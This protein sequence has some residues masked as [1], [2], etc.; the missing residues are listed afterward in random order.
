M[1]PACT[2]ARRC[3][4]APEEEAAAVCQTARMR[5]FLALCE[6]VS[7]VP[8]TNRRQQQ[9]GSYHPDRFPTSSLLATFCMLRRTVVLHNSRNQSVVTLFP[10]PT[11]TREKMIPGIFQIGIK[12]ESG[13]SGTEEPRAVPKI[14]SWSSCFHFRLPSFCLVEVQ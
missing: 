8:T 4:V 9:N 14:Q 13:F 3:W 10:K 11:L 2:T 1:V 5:S 7:V 12:S 6:L